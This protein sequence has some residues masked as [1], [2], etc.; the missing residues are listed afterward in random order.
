MQKKKKK[1]KQ[2]KNLDPY[3]TLQIRKQKTKQK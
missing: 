3:L 2:I 1:V